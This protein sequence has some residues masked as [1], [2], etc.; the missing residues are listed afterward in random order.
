M[1]LFVSLVDREVEF[2]V[3]TILIVLHMLGTF[4]FSY[5][6]FSKG[7]SQIPGFTLTSQRVRRLRGYQL[8]YREKKGKKKRKR[9]IEKKKKKI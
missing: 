1:Q 4:L 8:S 9:T 6:F 7:K 2:S 3:L 5:F